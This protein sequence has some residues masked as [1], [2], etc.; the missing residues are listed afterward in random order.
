MQQSVKRKLSLLPYIYIACAFFVY[1]A[2]YSVRELLGAVSPSL[3]ALSVFN[4][5]TLGVFS[6]IMFAFYG[7]GQFVNG[8]LGEKL[9][10]KFMI[11]AGL[12]SA[13]LC[14]L[15]FAITD[16]LALRYVL[17]AICGYSLSMLYGPLTK[18]VA[19]H[20]SSNLA[21]IA[22]VFLSVGAIL[23]STVAGFI[24]GLCDQW[25]VSFFVTAAFL[26]IPLVLFHIVNSRFERIAAKKKQDEKS[27]QTQEAV[28]ASEES[29]NIRKFISCF[30][31]TTLCFLAVNMILKAARHAVSFWAP[32][33][34]A[35]ALGFEPRTAALIF[36]LTAVIK[37]VAPFFAL[38]IYK[39]VKENERVVILISM[40]ISASC[41]C[42][43]LVIK[44]PLVQV[45]LFTVALFFIE[46]SGSIIGSV[47]LLSFK[48]FGCVSAIC[49]FFDSIAYLTAAVCTVLFTSVLSGGGWTAVLWVWT[50][51]PI[52]AGLVIAVVVNKKKFYVS[53]DKKHKIRKGEQQ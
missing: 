34:L 28:Q 30:G 33:Y 5:D 50:A 19:T 46:A 3:L 14:T 53:T 29:F 7:I 27:E 26:A 49:G 4:E 43:M 22:Y 23:G 16:S 21:R 10:V 48:Q 15:G 32:T 2:V 6:S 17:W 20:L 51:L 11:T 9:N 35:D 41:F 40:V 12:V 36:G 47:F 39:W 45:V 37:V 38:A 18:S 24:V 31:L 1:L 25:Y 52:A 44:N 42:S 13:A 8:F